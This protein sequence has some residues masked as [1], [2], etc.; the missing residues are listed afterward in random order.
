MLGIVRWI[1]NS[2]QQSQ[3]ENRFAN[4]HH[5]DNVINKFWWVCKM[6]DF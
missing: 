1:W 4:Y 6:K 2:K 3:E 5:L